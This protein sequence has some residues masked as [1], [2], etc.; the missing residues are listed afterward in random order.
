[1]HTPSSKVLLHQP[2]H[3]KEMKIKQ[4][5][6][7]TI[8]C[9]TNGNRG[10]VGSVPLKIT[11]QFSISFLSDMMQ[12]DPLGHF[13]LKLWLALIILHYIMLNLKCFG[14]N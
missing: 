5:Q 9:S 2:L 4:A 14:V 8:E 1:M 10:C 7:F 13:N 12:F 3:T 6:S 11:L